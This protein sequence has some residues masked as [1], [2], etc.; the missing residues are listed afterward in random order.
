MKKLSVIAILLALVVVFAGCNIIQVNQER[1]M[2]RVVIK[3]GDEVILKQDYVDSYNAIAYQSRLTKEQ[4]KDVEVAN[5]IQ[6]YAIDQVINDKIVDIKAHDLGC[7][8]FTQEELDEMDKTVNEMLEYYRNMAKNRVEGL[9]ENKDKTEE[10]LQDLIDKD[11]NALLENIKFDEQ[12]YKDRLTKQKA[13]KKLYDEVTKIEP[14][15]EGEI[16]SEYDKRVVEQRT[17]FQEGNLDFERMYINGDTIYYN[18]AG[19]RKARHILLSIPD[20]M[21][22]KIANLKEDNVEEAD[23]V[24]KEELAKIEDKAND[25]YSKLEEGADFNELVKEFGEDPGMKEDNVYVMKEDSQS[26]APEFVKELFSLKKK[27]EYTKPVASDFGYHIILYVDDLK[28]GTVAL[29]DVKEKIEDEL[30]TSKKETMYEEQ[31][32]TWKEQIKTKVYK[33]KLKYTIG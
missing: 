15:T 7:Y 30:T 28:E 2:E 20:D 21:R 13:A 1:D 3:V 17:G 32:N 16:Q 10:E 11:Y 18:P 9:E 6:E 5:K 31:M 24:L 33:S 25:V 8:E 29:E 4:L 19:M 26:F 22:S 23:K 14:I 12:D 27:G